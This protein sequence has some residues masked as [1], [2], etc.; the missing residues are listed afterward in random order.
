MTVVTTFV[1]RLKNTN[2]D[3]YA[4][5]AMDLPSDTTLEEATEAAIAELDAGLILEAI[6]NADTKESATLQTIARAPK[7]FGS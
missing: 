7:G 1:L 5:A 2:D 3:T 6:T 4:V